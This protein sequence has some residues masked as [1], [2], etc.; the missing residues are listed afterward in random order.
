LKAKLVVTFA[1]RVTVDALTVL[2]VLVAVVDFWL[3]DV[4]WLLEV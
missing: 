1:A 2:A 4:L 3:L